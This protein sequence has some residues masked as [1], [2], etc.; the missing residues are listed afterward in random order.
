MSRR[1]LSALAACCLAS[2]ALAQSPTPQP[3]SATYD[4]EWRGVTAGTSRFD[5]VRVGGTEFTYRSLNLARGFFRL[6]FPDAITQAS[7]FNI[8]DGMV[9]PVSYRADDGSSKTDR[10]ISLDFNWHEMAATGVVENK[11][12][13]VPLKPGAQ[14]SLSVQIALMIELAAGRSP[15]HFWLVDKTELKDYAYA[16]EGTATLTTPLGKIDTVIYTSTRLGVPA[17]GSTRVT[18]F[19]LAPSLGFLPLRAEQIRNGKREFA[20]NIK[21]LTRS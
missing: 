17:G 13:N 7:Q 9:K 1:Y 4:T 19:W 15:E 20:L 10:D 8:V 2:N 6:A 18:R 3:F 5:L 16:R 14:D 21:S 12:V 11:P